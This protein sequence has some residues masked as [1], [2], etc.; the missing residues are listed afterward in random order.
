M[1]SGIFRKASNVL[2]D[3]VLRRWLYLRLVGQVEALPRQVRRTPDYLSG[4]PGVNDAVAAGRLPTADIPDPGAEIHLDLAGT[5]QS[6]APGGEEDFVSQTFADTETLLAIHRFSWLPLSESDQKYE[7]ANAIW[8]AWINKFGRQEGWAWHPYTV[9]ERLINLFLAAHD[10]GRAGAALADAGWIAKHG[11]AILNGLE[12]FGEGQTGNHLANNG[13]GLYLAGLAF[14]TGSWV[15]AGEKLLL[16]HAKSIFLPSGELREGSTHYH[17][18]V[19]RWYLE[20]WLAAERHGRRAAGDLREICLAALGILPEFAMPAGLAL[21]GDVSPDCPPSYLESLVTGKLEGW[22]AQLSPAHQQ[23]IRTL[24]DEARE[25][26]DYRSGPGLWHRK[27]FGEWAVFWN[28]P[29]EGWPPQ[30]GHGHSD[31]GGFELHRAGERIFVDPGRRSYGPAGEQ[32]KLAARHNCL[33][34]DGHDA[35]PVNRAY[36]SD[37]FRRSIT[38]APPRYNDSNDSIELET[39]AFRRIPGVENWRRRWR[40]DG[41]ALCID[42]EVTGAGE[43][44]VRRYFQTALPVSQEPGAL[45]IGGHRF[46]ADGE[47]TVV[48]GAYWPAYNRAEKAAT[49]IVENRTRLPW[50]GTAGLVAG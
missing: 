26:H 41:Q 34:I 43:H 27:E 10:A 30:P 33:R 48:P 35:Y 44:V 39:G 25:R 12:Y 24:R 29:P 19:C 23:S 13:R 2:D 28:L 4:I 40:R 49:V 18:L 16:E 5:D 32:D 15:D 14:D 47:I 17:L 1:I 50:S 9:A 6:L 8:R 45:L 46:T 36:Y 20:C 42:D 22:L 7:W 11:Q 38:G 21:V 31:F 3:P 37:S